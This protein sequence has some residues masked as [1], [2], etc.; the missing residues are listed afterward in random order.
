MS[1]LI[2]GSRILYALAKDDLFGKWGEQILLRK[3]S[4]Y[5][6]L[7]MTLLFKFF[8]TYVNLDNEH[9]ILWRRF[10]PEIKVVTLNSFNFG[11]KSSKNASFLSATIQAS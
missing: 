7:K 11:H 1:N 2:G 8:W 5:E 3:M 9:D 4:P 10:Q 6:V